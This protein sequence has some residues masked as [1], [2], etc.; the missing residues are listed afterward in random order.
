MNQLTGLVF[1]T[2]LALMA[3]DP[4]DD[5]FNAARKGGL[6]TVK[7]LIEKGAP[8]EAKTAYGQ[9]PLYLA[10]MSGNQAVVQYRADRH[11]LPSLHAR[12]CP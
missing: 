8:L 11:F 7:A 5:L 12:F 3:A 2:A 4:N 6:D 1:V 9:T 10:T